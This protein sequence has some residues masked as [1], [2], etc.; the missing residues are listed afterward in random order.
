MKAVP[1]LSEEIDRKAFE[2]IEWLFHS[3][4]EGRLT[5]DQFSAGVDT[6]FMAVSGLTKNEFIDLITLAQAECGA[7]A[8]MLKRVFVDGDAVKCVTTWVVGSDT[9]ELTRPGAKSLEKMFDTSREARDWFNKVNEIM[10]ARGL[11]EI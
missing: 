1:T 7:S 10:N 6:L 4:H 5:Q 2:T 3:L 9:V 11:K 8:P